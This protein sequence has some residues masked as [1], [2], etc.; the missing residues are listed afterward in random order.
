MVASLVYF[1]LN[2]KNKKDYVSD[3]CIVNTFF[4]ALFH[5]LP[6]IVTRD[7][8]SGIKE[9]LGKEIIKGIEVE[10]TKNKIIK[11]LPSY[12][13]KNIEYYL[14]ILNV[15]IL[16]MKEDIPNEF[17]NR[18]LKGEKV[19]KYKDEKKFIKS[20]CNTEYKPVWGSLVKECDTTIAFAEAVYSIKHGLISKE[21]KKA[22]DNMYKDLIGKEKVGKL[23]KSLYKEI[24]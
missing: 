2:D 22:I 7:I 9:V 3:N 8:V 16:N 18:I 21:L 4:I 13:A 11:L 14:D 10:E 17:A 19:E 12:I 5:D 1:I 23:A 24:R 6:E 15:D 20:F